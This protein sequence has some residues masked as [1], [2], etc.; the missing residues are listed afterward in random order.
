MFKS[1]AD[2]CINF[3]GYNLQYGHK[4]VKQYPDVHVALSDIVREIRGGY[5]VSGFNQ[6]ELEYIVQSMFSLVISVFGLI[7][8]FSFT[9][10]L[11]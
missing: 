2:C 5:V 10:L 6:S 9:L 11:M 7:S 8:F 4:F 1:S 3:L